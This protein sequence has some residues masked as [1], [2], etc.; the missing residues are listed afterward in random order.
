MLIKGNEVNII[1]FQDFKQKKAQK[2]NSK[3]FFYSKETVS[4]RVHNIKKSLH[5][6]DELIHELR[7][8]SKNEK[9]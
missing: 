9:K 1:N 6:I 7:N 8:I 2:T 5:K 3:N 4:V